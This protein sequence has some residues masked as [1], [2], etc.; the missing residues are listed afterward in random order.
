MQGISSRAAGKLENRKK[1]NDGSELQSKEFSDGSGLELYS[2]TYRS[3]DPQL[4]RFH[5]I[6][7]LADVIND[8]SPYAFVLNNPL[9]FNDPHGLDTTRGNR[10]KPEP[11]PGDI[12]IPDE[13]P[14]KIFDTDRGWAPQVELAEVAVGGNNSESSNESSDNK[15][16]VY[17]V[18]LWAFGIGLNVGEGVRQV[19][20]YTIFNRS[21]Q[22]VEREIGRGN[23]VHTSNGKIYSQR[24]RG[25]QYVSSSSIKS[26]LSTAKFVKKIGK[27][28]TILSVATSITSYANSEQT[29][30]DKARLVGSLITTGAVAFP[31]VGPLLSIGL[32]MAD[33]F[34]AF[35]GF[36]DYFKE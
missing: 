26:S 32:G 4:G 7:P 28:L 30:A 14:I 21:L 6:D 10:P 16:D 34:G 13:G 2:T 11:A 31:V 15:S 12:W 9:L 22:V 27:G 8:C 29:G 36:Y 18:G 20:G 33:S 19:H 24:F 23:F 1:F 17:N 5:Q 25:N 35:D 3:Y